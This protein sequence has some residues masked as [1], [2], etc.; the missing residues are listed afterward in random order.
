MVSPPHEEAGRGLVETARAEI[1]PR[2]GLAILIAFFT[3][4]CCLSLAVVADYQSYVRYDGNRL[5]YAIATAAAFYLVSLPFVFTRFN[6]GYFVGFNFFTMVLGFLWL[7]RFSSFHYDHGLAAIS[8][9]A[10]AVLF[11]LPAVL[12]RKSVV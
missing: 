5:G 7:G 12:D 4:A 6:F 11:L 3:I 8:A 2:V 9:A 1:G 10:S